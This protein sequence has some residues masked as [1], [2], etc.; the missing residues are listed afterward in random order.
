MERGDWTDTPENR[1]FC[2]SEENVQSVS[3]NNSI[4]QQN[5]LFKDS[6]DI[7]YYADKSDKRKKDS[8][9]KKLKLSDSLDYVDD[10]YKNENSPADQGIA[11][12]KDGQ[13]D[14]KLEKDQK[15]T[16]LHVKNQETQS[17]G[18]FNEKS[19][20]KSRFHRWSAELSRSVDES[21]SQQSGGKVHD[22]AR[23]RHYSADALQD[24]RRVLL[25]ESSSLMMGVTQ[26][27]TVQVIKICRSFLRFRIFMT[28]FLSR[29]TL[30]SGN[31]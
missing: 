28:D 11:T 19:H 24:S 15:S 27:E 13:V 7:N 2:D 25:G 16:G 31:P 26:L 29:N 9:N 23:A 22:P 3:E 8:I 1:L 5:P 21:K 30:Y 17:D 4:N 18:K 14:S 10:Y 20:N 6:F 12:V